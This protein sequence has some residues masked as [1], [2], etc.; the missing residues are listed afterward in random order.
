MSGESNCDKVLLGE[1][2]D[3]T[4]GR[5]AE[6]QEQAK[7]RVLAN[8][9]EDDHLHWHWLAVL[10]ELAERRATEPQGSS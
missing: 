7:R 4:D 9:Y 6:M 1:R 5:L 2:V 10:N 8:F 3:V